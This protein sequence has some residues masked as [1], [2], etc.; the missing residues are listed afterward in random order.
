MDWWIDVKDDPAPDRDGFYRC[1]GYWMKSGREQEEDGVAYFGEWD[2]VNNFVLTHWVKKK[3]L[4]YKGYEASY[5]YDERDD[6]YYGKIE[7]IKDMIDFHSEKED[8]IEQQFHN[9]VDDYISF[10]K[11]FGKEPDRP[12]KEE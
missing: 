6:I 9:A 5:S 7:G 3:W 1:K 12:K 10:C 8:Q 2:I 4:K 11:D